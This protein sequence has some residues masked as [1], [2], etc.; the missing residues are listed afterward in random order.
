MLA[1]ALR[2]LRRDWRAGE[3]RVLAAA[4]VVAV[5]AVTA[6]G[7]FADRI[8]LALELQATE[9][10][11]ADLVISADHPLEAARLAAP[12][13]RALRR[14]EAVEFPS[15]VIAGD[16]AQL[17]SVRAVSPD[18]PLR[19]R[20]RV[21]R[22]AY[23]P[24]AEADGVPPAG[25]VWPEARLAGQLGV[26]V[27]DTVEL[28]DARLRVDAIL[29][30]EP[31][32]GGIGVFNL[33]PR[34]LFNAADL[35]ATG[36]VQPASRVRYRYLF[37]GEPDA[38]RAF[39]ARIEPALGRGESLESV[40]DA[41]PEVRGAL[42]RAGRFLG[43]ATLVS[44]L[45]SGVAVAL[46]AR[47]F[48]VRH[49]DYCA[50]MRCLGA[51]QRL[52]LGVYGLQLGLLGL[53]AALL[54]GAL[55]YLAQFGLESL[56]GAL[57]EIDLPPPSARPALLGAGVAL[58]TRLGFALPPLLHLRNVP[59]LRVIRR[60]LGG[61][62]GARLLS[63]LAGAAAMAALIWWQ[64]EDRLLSLYILL[65]AVAALALLA[66]TAAG[67]ILLL[68]PLRHRVGSTWRFGLLSL[69]QRAGTGV[70][71]VMAFGLGIL[72][73]LLLGVVRG[74]LLREWEHELPEQAPNRFLINILPEQVEAVRAFFARSGLEA[75][76]LFPMV[77]GRL[78]GIGERAVSAGLYE[79]DR[80][81]RLVEREF[82]LSWAAR[83]QPDNRIVA[84]AWWGEGEGGGGDG[85]AELSV[86]QGLAETLGIRLGD[87][88]TFRIAGADLRARVTSLRE[89]EWDNFRVN[90]F[91][92][93]PPGVLDAFPA[94]WITS[95]YVPADRYPVLNGLVKAFP[96]VTVIDVSAIMDQV[97][98]IMDRVALAVQYV[99]LFTLIAGVLVMAA[100]IHASLDERVRETV[101][102]RTLGAS[103]R[104]LLLGLA[105][106]FV[107]LGV[108]AGALGALGA[109]L[110]A[111][112]LASRVFHLAYHWD[113]ALW[114]IGALGGGL[115]VG[116]A[117]VLGTRFV[118]NTPPMRALRGL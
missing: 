55:G 62:G 79:D 77:R 18:Y 104:Q 37:A 32:G 53:T 39:R 19:G 88:L 61:P 75:P 116:L 73:L 102:L 89:V 33:A 15:M 85:A 31:A 54:G 105:T 13:G 41:R 69:T 111:Q 49:L 57:L 36:L 35:A 72:V 112:L 8:R 70:M 43:L 63:Y 2:M 42:D 9:L 86:E 117:G 83:A 17:A 103:R 38:V 52:V 1:L 115:G 84:G 100:A 81:R 106:E 101:L 65:G 99:F 95:L 21:S 51:S 118:L 66:A 30:V 6:V 114:L 16:Q 93:T 23:A 107:S 80:A 40:G 67:L 25:A 82:N 29:T 71:Q 34:L 76:E 97:R 11:G 60:E 46:S 50:V 48:I 24:D 64:A 28:G 56:L 26:A 68:R 91:V 3:L 4:L 45:L 78:T 12:D 22:E 59:A 58:V 109:G 27:G 74:D 44:V 108:V 5:A 47:R 110:I 87:T 20:L 98:R 10:L 113:P 7:F 90:F 14:A 96:N 94:T 92:L